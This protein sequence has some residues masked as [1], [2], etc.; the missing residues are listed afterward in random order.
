MAKIAN[1]T[2][3]KQNEGLK[4]FILNDN[5]KTAM[6]ESLKLFTQAFSSRE[7]TDSE[8][9]ILEA[10]KLINNNGI[11]GIFDGLKDLKLDLDDNLFLMKNEN[12]E[13]SLQLFEFY[14]IH[15]T[16]PRQI[17]PY[18]NWD[19]QN[20]LTLTENGKWDRRKNLQ[21]LIDCCIINLIQSI[22]SRNQYFFKYHRV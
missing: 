4:L 11:Q 15:P 12:N 22:E 14:E 3:E 6:K 8:F 13:N 18:G 20:G 19:S 7:R 21:V 16:V 10:T 5:S 1:T 17:L 9:W 2:A